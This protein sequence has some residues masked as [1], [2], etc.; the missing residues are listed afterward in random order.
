MNEVE[1][2][3]LISNFLNSILLYCKSVDEL[4]RY[5]VRVLKK[6]VLSLIMIECLI[7]IL[8]RLLIRIGDLEL[9]S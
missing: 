8:A 9:Y 4:K 5:K 2:F 6:T 1:V 7:A 3:V